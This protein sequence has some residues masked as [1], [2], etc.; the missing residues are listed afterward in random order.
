MSTA[1]PALNGLIAVTVRAG[2]VC[3][4]AD[5]VAAAR[6]MAAN[7]PHNAR[8]ELMRFL[9]GVAQFDARAA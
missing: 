9:P 3:A 5:D 7:A 8:I 4:S 6:A 2:Q 1:L